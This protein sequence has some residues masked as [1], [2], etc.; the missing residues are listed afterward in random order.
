MDERSNQNVKSIPH[1]PLNAL[2]AFEATARLG[3]M[4]AAAKE[5][6]VTHGAVSRHVNALEDQFGL[7][8]LIRLPRA[9][10][11]TPEGSAFAVQLSKA[12]LLLQE[13]V[14][15][16]A[17]GP[18]TLSCPATI[19]MKWLIPRLIEFKRENPG[20]EFRL[21]MSRGEVDF[22]RDK[23]S[24]AIRTSIALLYGRSRD[25]S[26]LKPIR[27]VTFID[28]AK[29][30]HRNSRAYAISQMQNIRRSVRY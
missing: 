14:A 16:L 23:V 13:A 27:R 21:N 1:L 15:Q 20:V 8:L 12:F 4:T 17:P 3:S 30:A 26:T 10:I 5:L 2:R 29:T 19:M 24:L 22:V 9:V 11:P 6:C 25:C 18:L 7:P 28:P